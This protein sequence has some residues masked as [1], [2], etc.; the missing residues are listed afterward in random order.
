MSVDD[1]IRSSLERLVQA[2]DNPDAVV[3]DVE[4]RAAKGRRRR[5]GGLLLV[6]AAVAV[7][8]ITSAV[9]VT[10]DRDTDRVIAGEAARDA[11]GSGDPE[12]AVSA[13]GL[14]PLRVTV[15]DLSLAEPGWLQHSVTL[16]N[17][18]DETVHLNDHRNGDFLGDREILAATDGCGPAYGPGEPVTVA[19]H[20]NY[21]PVRI[22]PGT[23]YTFRITLWRSMEGMNDI[24][25][26]TL[27]FR[28]SILIGTGSVAPNPQHFSEADL[29]LTYEHLNP[30]ASVSSIPSGDVSA[31]RLD[32]G[33]PV[34][35][36]RHLD[37]S[38]GTVSVLGA[39]STHRPFGAGT[40]VGWC[41]RSRGFE[42]QMH[43]STFDEW[44]GKRAGPAPDHLHRY[45]T[46][47]FGNTVVVG[48]RRDGLTPQ[49]SVGDEGDQCLGGDNGDPAPLHFHS[50]AEDEGVSVAEALDAHDGQ[51][52]LV[53]GASILLE[54]G[55][56]GRVCA[57]IWT[58]R[59]PT[60]VGPEAPDLSL[61]DDRMWA[62]L[63]GDFV[64][65]VR[66]GTLTEIT[67]V[68]AYRVDGPGGT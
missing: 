35:V 59:P 25:G 41:G 46:D 3:A 52:V 55:E 15:S 8:G 61:F 34:W 27:V 14:E 39:A 44:G 47:L 65:R 10:A 12:V 7:L 26:E 16:E 49:F 17:T 28:K 32:D 30:P 45:D 23:S 42:D 36:V 6:A 37:R 54:Q 2:V 20:L 38:V 58:S 68:G 66:A 24:S 62:L 56:P 18:G 13:Q 33:T 19:C 11:D 40:L 1:A 21:V 53:R 63:S 51:V 22:A 9:L 4:R 31:Q 5:P 29:V 48:E 60:C 57:T 50:I 64:T 67:F 43:G